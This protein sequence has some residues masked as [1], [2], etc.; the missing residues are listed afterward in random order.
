MPDQITQWDNRIREMVK[1]WESIRRRTTAATLARWEHH[2][3]GMNAEYQGL[4]SRGLWVSGPADFLSII[5]RQQDERTHSRVLAWL[6]TPTGRHGLR[7]LV[8]MS[9]LRYYDAKHG[10]VQALS[11]QSTALAADCSYRVECSYWRE[12]READIV[13]LGNDFTLIIEMKVNA[14]EPAGQCDD[15]YANF[16]DEPGARFLFLTRDGSKPRTATAEE[17]IR[18]FE[19]ISWLD[20][21]L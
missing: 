21:R 2:F 1:D 3:A 15:L 5:N 18:A 16:K 17:T 14:G 13:V 20:I 8:L 6:L 11:D 9:L 7:N 19:T 12:G 10:S 4:L